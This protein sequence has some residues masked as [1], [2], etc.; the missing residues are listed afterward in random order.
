LRKIAFDFYLFGGY[1]IEVIYNRLG[2]PI[3]YNHIDFMKFR[4]NKELDKVYFKPKWTTRNQYDMTLQSSKTPVEISTFD[5]CEEVRTR[6]I[7]Y[8]RGDRTRNIYPIPFYIGSTNAIETSIEIQNYH[9]NCIRNNF[10]VSAII[11]FNSGEPTEEKK[12]EIEA[13]IT[14]KLTGSENASSFLLNFNENQD[15]AITIERLTSDDADERFI[16]LSQDTKENIFIGHRVTSGAL[17]GVIDNSTSFNAVEYE[18]SFHIFNKTVIQPIQDELID[19][20]FPLF[21]DSKIEIIPYTIPQFNTT[22]N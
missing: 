4:I 13:G 15:S 9:K 14:S 6:Q 12:A 17:F 20:L 2:Q 22:I 3:E 21:P 19:S 1:A 18:N 10:N 7:Y 11:N 5:P 8:Y 16:Q